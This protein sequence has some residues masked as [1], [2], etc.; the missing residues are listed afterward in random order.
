MS[1]LSVLLCIILVDNH[2]FCLIYNFFLIWNW[3]RVF[4]LMLNLDN[5]QSSVTVHFHHM[6][7]IVLQPIYSSFW[8]CL[9]V[10][11]QSP[12]FFCSRICCKPAA[13]GGSAA[14]GGSVEEATGETCESN[15]SDDSPDSK[16]SLELTFAEAVELYGTGR[17]QIILGSKWCSGT[18]RIIVDINDFISA[19][20]YCVYVTFTVAEV[21]S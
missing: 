6:D 8:H 16:G 19:C 15:Q 11:L 1:N 12:V 20:L 18:F 17:Y 5:R 21:N 4:L 9:K 10:E 2:T 3:M 14:D 7:W 13:V